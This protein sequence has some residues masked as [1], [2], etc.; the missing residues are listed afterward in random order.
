VTE[1]AKPEPQSRTTDD[2]FTELEGQLRRLRVWIGTHTLAAVTIGGLLFYGGALLVYSRFYGA[3]GLNPDEAGLDYTTTLARTVTAFVVWVLNLFGLAV[4]LLLVV[5]PLLIVV[6]ILRDTFRWASSKTSKP[7][8]PRWAAE[9]VDSGAEQAKAA[10]E[11]ADAKPAENAGDSS[12]D[13]VP[14]WR[15]FTS[16][17]VIAFVVL[18][19]A[20]GFLGLAFDRADQLAERVKEGEEIRPLPEKDVYSPYD[21]IDFLLDAYRNPLGLRVE[22]VS[23]SPES[24]AQL[25]AE[26]DPIRTYAYLGRSR[27]T[28]IL[29]DSEEGRTLRVPAALVVLSDSA[30]STE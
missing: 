28:I 20:F 17:A 7:S 23:V 24:T 18:L 4:L 15:Q 22:R 16:I 12:E 9:D 3:F 30:E 2:W 13:D 11:P 21:W 14:G 25:P 1:K 27:D 26:L 8:G 19:L 10:A 29:Y 6:G 5:I